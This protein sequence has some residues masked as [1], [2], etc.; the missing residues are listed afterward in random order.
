MSFFKTG[1]SRPEM[2]STRRTRTW[3]LGARKKTKKK[4]G[5][6]QKKKKKEF[7]YCPIKYTNPEKLPPKKFRCTG[8]RKSKKKRKYYWFFPP[9]I[10][11]PNDWR[12]V[13]YCHDYAYGEVVNFVDAAAGQIQHTEHAQMWSVS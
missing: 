5:K 3:E 4:R 9:K 12:S 6:K 13:D 1:K 11:P 8:P 2:R 7:S 10:R